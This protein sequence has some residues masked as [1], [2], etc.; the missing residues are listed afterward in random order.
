MKKKKMYM[1]KNQKIIICK[2]NLKKNANLEKSA[3]LGILK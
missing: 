1:H 2:F 3:N